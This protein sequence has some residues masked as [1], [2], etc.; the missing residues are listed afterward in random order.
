M[1]KKVLVGYDGSEIARAAVREAASIARRLGS[2]LE[3]VYVVPP[4]NSAILGDF[5]G[6]AA[7]ELMVQARAAAE[8]ALAEIV[9]TIEGVRAT[10]HVY[11]D[12]PAAKLAALARDP[13]IELVV[14]GKAGASAMKRLLLGSVAL[15]LMHLCEKPLV[16]IPP[17]P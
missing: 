15:K 4:L 9:R 11:S 3:V 2:E 14:V 7:N 6:V 5:S 17:P 8:A 1:P 13:E 12:M 10:T 16:L